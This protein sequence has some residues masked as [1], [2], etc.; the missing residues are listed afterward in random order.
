MIQLRKEVDQKKQD[1]K[2][3]LRESVSKDRR[4]LLKTGSKNEKQEMI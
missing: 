1:I 2:N 4:Y 3:K